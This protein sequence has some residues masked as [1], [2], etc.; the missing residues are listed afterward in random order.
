MAVMETLTKPVNPVDIA[1]KS[2]KN[3]KKEH[4]LDTNGDE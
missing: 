1:D 4:E 2:K 3:N